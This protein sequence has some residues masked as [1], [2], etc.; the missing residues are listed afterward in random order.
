[1]FQGPGKTPELCGSKGVRK[2]KLAG[3]I[4]GR[5]LQKRQ[6][7]GRSKFCKEVLYFSVMKNTQRQ[8]QN[9]IFISIDPWAE[10]CIDVF[11]KLAELFP[12]LAGLF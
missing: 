4:C 7:R 6:K 3:R 9:L 10:R 5:I 12:N 2:K 8:R 11:V 1:M